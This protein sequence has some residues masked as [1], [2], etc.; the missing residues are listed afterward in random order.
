MENGTTDDRLEA[1]RIVYSLGWLQPVI[2]GPDGVQTEEDREESG[3]S[4]GGGESGPCKRRREYPSQGHATSLAWGALDQATRGSSANRSPS[5][6][7]APASRYLSCPFEKVLRMVRYRQVLLVDG[8]ALLTPWQ[9][10][11]AVVQHF[12][13]GL[14]KEMAVAERGLPGVEADERVAAVL[15]QVR[16]GCKVFFASLFDLS[17]GWYLGI[18]GLPYL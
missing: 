14:R 2:M 4:G 3:G 8:K 13:E 11:S 5:T 7:G 15:R 16:Y 9:V 17:S 10:P 1:L 12:E 18:F 6:S